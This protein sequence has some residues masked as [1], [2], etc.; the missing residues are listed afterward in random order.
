M[1]PLKY[2]RREATP[3]GT[4]Q[5]QNYIIRFQ[6]S[7]L[8]KSQILSAFAPSRNC[9]TINCFA[10]IEEAMPNPTFQPASGFG[11]LFAISEAEQGAEAFVQLR[12][13]TSFTLATYSPTDAVA[14]P[15]DEPSRQSG[16]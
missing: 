10:S 9:P 11:P 12:R 5:R 16:G 13:E 6:F 14:V 4:T 3:C 1:R 2:S 7:R 8:D 15:S